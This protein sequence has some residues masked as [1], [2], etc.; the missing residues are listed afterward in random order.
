MADQE[1]ETAPSGELPVPET[2]PETLP[3]SHAPALPLETNPPENEPD[4]SANAPVETGLR[5]KI[6]T[7][8]SS[9]FAGFRKGKGRPKKCRACGGD[10]C[11]A[12]KWTGVVPGKADVVGTGDAIAP[13]READLPIRQVEA[14]PVGLSL[15]HI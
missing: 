9:L 6:R 2:T 12:C 5:E 1:K 8:T 7:A 15:I 13:G 4:S 10:G 11:A 14:S 3:M